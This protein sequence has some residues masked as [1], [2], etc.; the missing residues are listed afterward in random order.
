MIESLKRLMSKEEFNPGILGIFLNPYYFARKGLYANIS[1]YAANISGKVLDVGCGRKP[2]RRLFPQVREYVGL[3]I[4]TPVA[5]SSS[6]ADV[7]YQ[8]ATFPFP[9]NE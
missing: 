2:Y 7:Y 5:R 4:D 1:I 3:E 6:L 8:G 9:E